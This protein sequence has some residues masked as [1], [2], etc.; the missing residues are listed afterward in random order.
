[1]C[2]A[3]KRGVPLRAECEFGECELGER[4]ARANQTGSESDG[5]RATGVNLASGERKREDRE[6]KLFETRAVSRLVSALHRI[7]IGEAAR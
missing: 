1:M 3:E 4:G 5:Q 2:N 7:G 6:G